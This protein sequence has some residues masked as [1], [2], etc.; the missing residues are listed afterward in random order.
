MKFSFRRK[1]KNISPYVQLALEVLKGKSESLSSDEII[2]SAKSKNLFKK[3]RI[4]ESTPAHVIESHLQ[5]YLNSNG[6]SPYTYIEGKPLRFLD[7]KNLPKAG[8]PEDDGDN[9]DIFEGKE[10]DY[11]RL[12]TYF[13]YHNLGECF[14]RST[15][16][17]GGAPGAKG[18]NFHLFPDLIGCSFLA[19]WQNDVEARRLASLNGGASIR[20]FSF[21]VKRELNKGSLRETSFEAL[22]N[23]NWAN[24][25]YIASPLDDELLEDLDFKRSCYQ[26]N[27]DYGLGFIHLNPTKPSHSKL[28]FQA[29]TKEIDYSSLGRL[30]KSSRMARNTVEY[31]NDILEN[32]S[33]LP[34]C[35]NAVDTLARYGKESEEE[36]FDH[37]F[38]ED[39]LIKFY[40]NPKT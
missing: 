27:Q 6:K 10:I 28:L 9:P 34:Q 11:H 37:V 26:I 5:S 40:S 35:L 32:R 1:K 21:E 4:E 15:H 25:T 17:G 36:Q 39:E 31:I 33:Q 2:S 7:F 8:D 14:T 3:F 29:K 20:L 38:N 12:L 19:K 18:L 30:L 13:A 22:A 23:S 24:V 16:F